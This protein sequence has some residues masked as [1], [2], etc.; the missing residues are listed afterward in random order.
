MAT[1]QSA[2]LFELVPE[3]WFE[4][5]VGSWVVV[6]AIAGIMLTLEAAGTLLAPL[7]GSTVGA[8]F[9]TTVAAAAAYGIFGYGATYV[10][11]A[12]RGMEPGFVVE[13]YD[14]AAWRCLGGLGLLFGVLVV[15]GGAWTTLVGRSFEVLTPHFVVGS[16]PSEG[17]GQLSLGITGVNEIVTQAPMVGLVAVLGG[18]LMGPAVGA[19]FHGVLQ[20]M[21]AQMAS[22]GVALAGTALAATLTVRGFAFHGITSPR[23]FVAALVTFVFVLGV[24]YAYR[25]TGNLLVPMAAYGLCSAL[26]LVLSWMAI[27]ASLYAHYGH[28]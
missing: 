22:R 14:R 20:N 1:N 16:P 2:D 18:V 10:Y 11:L 25:Q 23:G 28:I 4:L 24:T 12:H 26:T 6:L 5:V 27:V 7:G 3:E 17:L 9:A 8:V 21:L 15:L 13:P 19:L